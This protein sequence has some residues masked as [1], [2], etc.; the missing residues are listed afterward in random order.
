MIET[1]L[2]KKGKKGEIRTVIIKPFKDKY[3]VSYGV[4][5]GKMQT[6]TTYPKQKNIG[7]S[8]ETSILEQVLLECTSL[9]QSKQDRNGYT[10]D[11]SGVK[12]V[13]YPMKIST[14][15]KH[16]HKLDYPLLATVKLNGVNATY[17]LID[18]ELILTSRTATLYHPIPHLETRIKA[19]MKYLNVT[20]FVGELFIPNTSLQKIISY[21]KKPKEQS[22]LLEFHIFDIPEFEGGYAE[23][24]VKCATL[25][26]KDKVYFTEVTKLNNETELIEMHRD[27]TYDGYE[28]L[29]LHN[30]DSL[31]IPSTRS[32]TS[33]KYKTT[34]SQ[35]YKIIGYSIDKL[36]HPV[37]IFISDGGEFKAKPKGTIQEREALLTNADLLIGSFATIEFETLGDPAKGYTIGKPLKPIMIGLR[38]CDINEEPNE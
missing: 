4:L 14:F 1:Q 11:E 34:L 20:R 36:N 16:G 25:I 24:I 19:M 27:V 32:T 2:Y 35:E 7:R 18:D 9:V 15:Q 3:E 28:G 23:R 30:I 31:Y 8:N 37:F 13:F 17:T 33:M 21:V 38:D 29:V 5:N 12:D 6:Q 10:T 26:D 22:K